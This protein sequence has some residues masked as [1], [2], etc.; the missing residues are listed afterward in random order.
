MSAMSCLGGRAP[1]TEPLPSPAVHGTLSRGPHVRRA[2]AAST[3]TLS[4]RLKFRGPAIT[5][6]MSTWAR[7]DDRALADHEGCS[8]EI[9]RKM[10]DSK[11][12]RGAV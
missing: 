11:A 5:V 2:L 10:D 6:P 4:V 7:H 1:T 12:S 3:T 9:R 8:T